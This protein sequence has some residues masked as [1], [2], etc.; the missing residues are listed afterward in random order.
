MTILFSE[1]LLDSKSGKPHTPHAFST[2]M[3]RAV[4]YLDSLETYDIIATLRIGYARGILYARLPLGGS[5]QQS[6]GRLNAFATT[7]SGNIAI[8][9]MAQTRDFGTYK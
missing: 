3:E 8:V 4:E 9:P 7:P 2:P 1:N 6:H 5:L